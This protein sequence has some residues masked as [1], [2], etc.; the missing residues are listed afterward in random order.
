MQS[1]LSGGGARLDSVDII[2]PTALPPS[3]L[4]RLNSEIFVLTQPLPVWEI[5]TCR[6]ISFLSLLLPMYH[7]RRR[8]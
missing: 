4:V 2:K 1:Q 7:E 6:L 8:I 5:F 3:Q